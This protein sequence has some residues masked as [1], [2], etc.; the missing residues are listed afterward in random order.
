MKT[1]TLLS[2][3]ILIVNFLIPNPIYSQRIQPVTDTVTMGPGYTNEIYYSMM[4]GQQGITDRKLWDIAFKTSRM[5]ACILT[6]DGAGVELY[7]YANS[8]ISGWNNFDTTGFS[9]WIPMFNSPDD[10]ETGAFNRY[11]SGHP[12]YG[13]GLYNSVTHDV[14]GDSLFLIKLRNGDFKKLWIV[15][16][17]SVNNI[18]DIR[19]ANLDGTEENTLSIDCSPYTTKNFV[20][21]DLTTSSLIDFEPVDK[22]NWDLLFTKYMGIN[23]GQ[24]YPVTGV[25]SN[26]GIKVNKFY[27]VALNYGMWDLATMDSTRSPIGYDWKVFNGATFTYEIADSTVYFVQDLGGNI[28]RLVFK[29]FSG[30]GTGVIVFEKEM[31]SANGISEK[32]LT[33]SLAVY[34][35]PAND[36]IN[37]VINPGNAGRIAYTLSAVSGKSMISQQAEVQKNEL[38]TV[39]I[40]TN[41]LNPGIYILQVSDGTWSVNRKVILSR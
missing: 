24:P 12:D 29:A 37:L 16:K 9:S 36:Y 2:I 5:S 28:H 27:P 20:G 15:K 3:F 25:L 26:I 38:N 1:T 8:D 13:W 18:Y 14:V 41:S 21:F 10:W 30:S 39:R 4:N 11:Q 19:Y 7:T 32:D 35:N 6:N 33:A 22:T 23:N 31:I 40:G 34:P 17:E